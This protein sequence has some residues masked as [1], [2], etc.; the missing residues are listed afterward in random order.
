MNNQDNNWMPLESNPEVINTFIAK[1]GL[2]TNNFCF[3]ELLGLEDWALEMIP[4]PVLGLMF[5]YQTTPVQTAY[6]NTEADHLD[7]ATVPK[8]M[9]YMKQYA[10][11]ACGTIALFHI[12]INSMGQHQNLVAPDCEI[13][14]FYQKSLNEG[15]EERG[16]SF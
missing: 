10:Q 4:Q 8:E 12:I 5:L 16:K 9:F 2:N 11:N 14:K 6:K 7:P 13:L 15:P 3:Q 1:M